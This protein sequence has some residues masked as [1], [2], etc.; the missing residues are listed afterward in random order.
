MQ[1]LYEVIFPDNT[2]Q[3]F[4]DKEIVDYP[5]HKVMFNIMEMFNED[6]IETDDCTY[7][8]RYTGYNKSQ[9]I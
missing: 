2:N 7:I 3:V 5:N 8:M 4:N 9:W 1:N 6:E